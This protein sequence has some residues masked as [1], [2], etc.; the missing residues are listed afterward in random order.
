ME[1]GRR[2][3][4]EGT[5]RLRRQQDQG[6][7]VEG[8][9]IQGLYRPCPEWMVT[10]VHQALGHD[11]SNH[12]HKRNSTT[13]VQA[14]SK[15]GAQGP[16][17]PGHRIS[18]P[19]S[20]LQSFGSFARTGSRP[21][22]PTPCSA[23]L[24]A[25]IMII[26][27]TLGPK[28]TDEHTASHHARRH[29]ETPPVTTAGQAELSSAAWSSPLTCSVVTYVPR[30]NRP[31]QARP[32]KRA[33]A[34]RTAGGRGSIRYGCAMC[35]A[36]VIQRDSHWRHRN[37]NRQRSPTPGPA[38]V[39]RRAGRRLLPCVPWC[40]A[41]CRR[42]RLVALERWVGATWDTDHLPHSQSAATGVLPVP[43]QDDGP[44]PKPASLY[45]GDK[46]PTAPARCHTRPSL[47]E[48]RSLLVSVAP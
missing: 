27:T 22:V 14:S 17:P 44:Q 12:R 25:D 30:S 7:A 32:R 38:P 48:R 37:T 24:G 13:L 23:R 40:C 28:S 9:V 4:F 18:A 43:L 16:G 34:T 36:R 31:V 5:R 1:E 42:R 46:N 45:P 21:S 29:S 39:G 11:T 41:A 10:R 19:R 47:A 3:G 20:V 8:V 6:A 15:E 33:R 35:S 2:E 26:V